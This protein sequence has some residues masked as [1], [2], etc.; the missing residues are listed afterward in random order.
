MKRTILLLAALALLAGACSSSDESVATV[1]DVDLSREDVDAL[2]GPI[3]EE[4]TPNEFA[5]FLSAFLIWEAVAQASAEE[6]GIEISDEEAK[7]RLDQLIAE[8][9][10][11]A[12]IEDVMTQ[13]RLSEAGLLKAAT[14]LLIEEQV[15]EQLKSSSVLATVADADDEIARD[16][17]AWTE[18]VCAA[19][20]LV[21]TEE[22]AADVV[23]KLASGED[24]ASI[25]TNASIDPGS[26]AN[27]GDLGCTA[28]SNYVAEFADATVVAA[29]GVPTDPVESQ[30]G[31]HIILV[32][33]RTVADTETVLEFLNSKL[34]DAWFESVFETVVITVNEEVGEWV[35]DPVP[36]VLAPA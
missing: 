25:A 22:E 11:G 14:E 26:G 19:H 2:V 7:A 17:V 5:S 36:R 4:M 21:A 24:F 35:T 3:D 6:F 30:F 8:S 23:A 28:P 1:G 20:I 10:P 29:I 13:T 34:L 12:S 15:Q 9:A 31:Y 18:E 16:P 33:S 27:G 32:E